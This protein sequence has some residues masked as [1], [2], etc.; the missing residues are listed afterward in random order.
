MASNYLKGWRIREFLERTGGKE[1]VSG[2]G[3]ILGISD[4]LFVWYS[5]VQSL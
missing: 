5:N 1:R 4:E 2:G 3:E